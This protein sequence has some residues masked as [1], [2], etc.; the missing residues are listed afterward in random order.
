MTNRRTIIVLEHAPHVLVCR[1]AKVL[2]FVWGQ[3]MDSDEILCACHWMQQFVL[4]PS[5]GFALLSV[6]TASTPV[7]NREMRG[8]S[9]E[10]MRS[11]RGKMIAAAL[12]SEASGI[13]A[14]SQRFIARSMAYVFDF[15]FPINVG[16][17]IPRATEWLAYKLNG[18][19]DAE[20]FASE[21][22]ELRRE[23]ACAS[24]TLTPSS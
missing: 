21:L 15:G 16:S 5:P 24:P 4:E 8:M 13:K 19:I 23:L 12:A 1:Y 18:E 6:V 2:I 17:S 22:A 9:G 14:A 7:P 11:A 10:I 20:A 3:R